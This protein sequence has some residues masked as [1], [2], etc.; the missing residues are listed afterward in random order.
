MRRD[1]HVWVKSDLRLK[2]SQRWGRHCGWVGER[3]TDQSSPPRGASH[4]WGPQVSRTTLPAEGCSSSMTPTFPFLSEQRLYLCT[5]PFAPRFPT[6]CPGHQLWSSW[7][8]SPSIQSWLFSWAPS[9][10]TPAVPGKHLGFRHRL[11]PCLVVMEGPPAPHG[12]TSTTTP[13]PPPHP[14]PWSSE[15]RGFLPTSPRPGRQLKT[16][17][18]G[19][20]WNQNHLAFE[21]LNHV[22]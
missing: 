18:W 8:D 10:S 21:F 5:A 1:E 2:K 4:P 9:L 11:A 13:I 6:T 20:L 22:L 19:G 16:A 15:L 12:G 7:K 17:L 14:L 3:W